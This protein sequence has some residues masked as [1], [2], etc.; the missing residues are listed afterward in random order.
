MLRAELELPLDQSTFWTDS[1]SVLKYIKNEDRRFH[2]FVANRV[3]AIRGATHVS[4]WR[5]IN[6]KDNPADYASRGMKVKDL[7]DGGSW[8]EGPRFLFGLEEDWPSDITEVT[9]AADDVEVKRDAMVNII[10]TQESLNATDQ[11]LS[12]F[13]DWGKLK[14]S[15]AWFL[16][17]KRILLQLSQRRKEL[18]ALELS[19]KDV[20]REMQRAKKAMSQTLSAKDLL[21]AEVSIIR[22]SQQERFKEEIAALLA[23]KSVARG[24]SIFKLDPCLENGLVRVGG[25][26][27]KASL[28]E[29]TKHPLILSKEQHIST[30][31]LRHVHQ[32][33]GHGGRNHT[34]S[35]LRRRFWITSATSAVRKVISQCTFCRRHKSKLGEQKMADLPKERLLPDLPPF[36]NVGVDYFGPLEVRRGR[37]V[38]KRYGV[39]FTCFA[40]RAVHLEVATSLDTSACINALRRFISRR[41]QVCSVRSDNGTNFVGAKKELK[42]A[43]ASLNHQQIQRVLLQ[44]GI[45][46]HFNPPGASHHGG[47]WERVIRMV[48]SVLTSVLHLQTLDDD[49]LHTVLCEVEAILN[50]RPLT[51]LSDDPADLEPLTPNHI[52]LMKGKPVLAPGLFTKDDVYVKR[53]WR[54]VQYI[55][56]LFWKRWVQEYL[57]L[58]QERHKWN[59][60]ERNFVPGDIVVVMDAAAPRGSWPLGRILETFPDKKGLVRSVRLRTRTSILERPVTKLCLLCEAESG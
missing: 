42:E 56:D 41:G 58:L 3:S 46:W 27:A 19:R 51:K 48:R 59:K 13:S 38:C 11:L 20:L 50:G 57:P 43:L 30:L 24:S 2:T 25:R 23:G 37:G 40:S 18:H 26:L 22:Y 60:R 47:V 12:Y 45:Q 32:Q 31:I 15:V 44:E 1:T 21:D 4:Q 36:T 9:I 33:V 29:E 55:A 54:Q 17:W 7:L 53:R 52:L 35:R 14:V 49:G 39:I 10:T 8:I 5:Y 34:L 28:P 6:T 16:K